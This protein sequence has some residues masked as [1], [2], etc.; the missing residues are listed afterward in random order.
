MTPCNQ[1]VCPNQAH[2]LV[3][4]DGTWAGMS[5]LLKELLCQGHQWA[6]SAVSKHGGW[7]SRTKAIPSRLK[8]PEAELYVDCVPQDYDLLGSLNPLEKPIFV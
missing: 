7:V 2:Y 6:R 5:F 8:S 4:T 1:P 3:V